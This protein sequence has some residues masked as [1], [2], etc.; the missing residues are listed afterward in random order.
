MVAKMLSFLVHPFTEIAI[1]YLPVFI[2]VKLGT[3]IFLLMR[4]IIYPYQA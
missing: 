1:V 3:E 4:K 2:S